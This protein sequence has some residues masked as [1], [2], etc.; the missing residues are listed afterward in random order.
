M[1]MI[2]EIPIGHIRPNPWQP[3]LKPDEDDVQSLANSIERGGL[4]NPIIV[5]RK[6]HW[7]EIIAGHRRFRAFKQLGYKQI[8]AIIKEVSD[9][10][11]LELT[12]VEN[13]QRKTI[14]PIE[15]AKAF[16]RLQKDFNLTQS[17][18]A[19]NLG[20]TR[21]YVGQRVRLLSFPEEIQEF[22]SHDTI[23]VSVAEA[24]VS[25]P[26]ELAPEIISR[27]STGYRPTVTEIKT[28][29][30]SIQKRKAVQSKNMLADEILGTI[31]KLFN[32]VSEDKQSLLFFCPICRC[33]V[34]KPFEA[35]G[36]TGYVCPGCHHEI[37]IEY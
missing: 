1:R 19:S 27:I 28:E 37:T 5:R 18:I 15:E 34:L 9:Q 35:D 22:V 10:Q 24:I 11:M 12:L 26:Q 31:L 23:S 3:R 33:D 14:T 25:A 17:E 4:L 21:D 16:A 13:L 6:D 32:E 20:L 29:I 8:P 7:H 30:E 36:R 2:K